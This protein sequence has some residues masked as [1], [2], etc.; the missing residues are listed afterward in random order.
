MALIFLPLFA[1]FIYRGF[2]TIA[3]IILFVYILILGSQTTTV[4]ILGFKYT[5]SP[6]LE[7]GYF[8]LLLSSI[9]LIVAGL[10]KKCRWFHKLSI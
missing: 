4:S 3:G 1:G 10:I 2:S 8:I 5:A 9:F 6:H 7:A